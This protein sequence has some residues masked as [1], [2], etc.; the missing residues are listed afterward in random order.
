MK[1]LTRSKLSGSNILLLVICLVVVISILFMNVLNTR[2]LTALRS[3]IDSLSQP[4]TTDGTLVN[5]TQELMVAENKFRIYL[6]TGDSSYKAEFLGHINRCVTNLNLVQYSEDSLAVNKI[7]DGLD[8]K[9]EKADS[10]IK[11][12]R[13]VDAMSSKLNNVV[14]HSEYSPPQNT[15]NNTNAAATDSTAGADPDQASVQDSVENNQL[16]SVQ[17]FY[18]NFLNEESHLRNQLNAGEK[19]LAETNLAIIDQLNNAINIVAQRQATE[20]YNKNKIAVLRAAEARNSIQNLSW[21]SFVIIIVIVLILVINIRR[22]IRYEREIIEAREKAEKLAVI[23]SR[24]LNNM[25]H[26]IRSPLTSI[27]GFTEQLKNAEFDPEKRKF[28][29]AIHTSSDHLL[30]TVND[31][32]DFSKLDA[33]KLMLDNTPFNIFNTIEEVIYSF[34]IHAEKKGIQLNSNLQI[35][36]GLM[37][38]GDEF[39]LRQVLFNLTGNAIKFTSKGSV[40]VSANALWKSEDDI[41]LKVE[42]LDSGTGIPHDQ[43]DLIFEE[44]AQATN[45]KGSDGRRSIRGTGLGLPI[46]KMLVEMH[47]GHITV[48]SELNKGS[49]FTVNIPYKVAKDEYNNPLSKAEK[50]VHPASNGETTFFFG[51]KALV[52]EDNDMNIMLLTLLLKKFFI[53]F[54]VAKDGETGLDLYNNGHYD[55]ILTDINVPKMTGDQLAE[56]IRRSKDPVKCKIPIIALTASIV[57]DDLDSYRLSGINEILIKPFKEAEFNQTLKKYLEPETVQANLV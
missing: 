9:V 23:K 15:L 25:S 14:F 2:N 53:E 47:G 52:V 35:E 31:V 56:A 28:L 34:T 22:S 39:R 38:N 32:L 8:L 13:Q 3:S 30:N 1:V 5:T 44:F 37:V 17:Q 16:E 20:E 19:E 24:F 6:S 43:M 4:N 57:A 45:N 10:I 46:C 11:L 48:E 54:D 51:K 55:I 42:I 27:I 33:G 18:R 40:T 29:N 12:H 49:L 21:F 7:L 41:Q 26:E 36:K 50:A